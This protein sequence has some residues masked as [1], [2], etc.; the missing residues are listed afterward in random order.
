MVT[1]PFAGRTPPPPQEPLRKLILLHNLSFEK[2]CAPVWRSLN[3]LLSDH[4]DRFNEHIAPVAGEAAE[5]N[6]I[7]PGFKRHR[8]PQLLALLIRLREGHRLRSAPLTTNEFCLPPHLPLKVTL[9]R[10]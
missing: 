5:V 10:N 8:Y 6:L 4:F 7:A 1:L 2:G 9:S 3:V